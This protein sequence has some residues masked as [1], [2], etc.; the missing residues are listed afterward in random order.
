MVGVI[1]GERDAAETA[2]RVDGLNDALDVLRQ[3]GTGI[4][5][6]GGVAADDP[7]VGARQ[8][9]RAR[10]LRAQAHDAV[11]GQVAF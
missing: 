9:Q 10:V 4:D 6:V 3:R 2:A 5:H 1:V 8:R 7:G 11:L